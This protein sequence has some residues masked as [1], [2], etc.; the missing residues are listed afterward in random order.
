MADHLPTELQLN[1]TSWH[2]ID[3]VS[4]LGQFAASL[5]I[6]GHREK[7]LYEALMGAEDSGEKPIKEY[8]YD[9]VKAKN[10]ISERKDEKKVVELKLEEVK[11]NIVRLEEEGRRAS[12]F[13]MEQITELESKIAILERKI[14]DAEVPF[15][16]D[17][18]QLTGLDTLRKF[19]NMIKRTTKRTFTT[20][21]SPIPCIHLIPSDST[22]SGMVGCIVDEFL[23]VEKLCQDLV[24]WEDESK[25]AQ[26]A[27]ELENL[28]TAWNEACALVIGCE[29]KEKAPAASPNEGGVLGAI[30]S[31]AGRM[32]IDSVASAK[33]RKLESP[34]S[35]ASAGGQASLHQIM[36]HLKVRS[37]ILIYYWS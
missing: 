14:A 19:D 25:R 18:A 23:N 9:D 37:R 34:G 27:T 22:R 2:A 30:A 8:M 28:A 7:A 13:Q 11:L 16:P 36:S 32:S 1:R 24:P 5:D 33:K 20:G 3:K 17:Y 10:A 31:P 35:I 15:V 12:R 29:P 6:R 4:T 26:W 21:A